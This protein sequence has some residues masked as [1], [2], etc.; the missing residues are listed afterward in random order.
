MIT[1][2]NIPF[3]L[4]ISDTQQRN[5][6]HTWNRTHP[7]LP[8]PSIVLVSCEILER[9]FV[10]WLAGYVMLVGFEIQAWS[11]LSL[12]VLHVLLLS[13]PMPKSPSAS[14]VKVVG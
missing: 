4:L 12:R 8:L 5:H 1:D 7:T 9:F 10:S 11:Q 2:P 14:L 3:P 13:V 6:L